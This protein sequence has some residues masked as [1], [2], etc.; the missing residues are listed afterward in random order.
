MRKKILSLLLVAVMAVSV[1]AC[2]GNGNGNAEVNGSGR[3]PV[4]NYVPTYPI[5]EEP[6]TITALVVGE[7]TTV[8][9]TR[10]LW[11]EVEALTIF[12]L[13]GNISMVMRSQHA[14]HQVTGQT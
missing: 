3:V 9:K 13:N 11:D 7:D 14:L 4:K 5:V 1:C 8:S 10:I 12:T 2:G 6:I